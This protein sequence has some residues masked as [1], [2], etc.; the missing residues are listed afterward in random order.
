MLPFPLL[1]V[2]AV[3]ADLSKT[4]GSTILS[5]R[6]ALSS[7]EFFFHFA[8][9]SSYFL[10]PFSSPP[11]PPNPP[12]TTTAAT[13][14]IRTRTRT[15]TETQLESWIQKLK[16]RFTPMD[17][18]DALQAQ[19]DADLAFDIFRWTSLQRHYKHTDSTYLT[20]I[21]ILIYGKRFRHAETLAE[22]VIAGACQPSVPLYNAVI[23]FC[24]ARKFL[25]NH[26]FDVYKKMLKSDDCKP[27]LET[28]TLLLNLLLKKFNRM[29]VCYMYLHSVRSMTKQMKSLGV[30]PD[31]F[32]L[33]MIIKAY[34]KCLD[35][36]EAIR[37]FREMGL[38]GCVPNAY[39]YSYIIKG[40]CEKGRVGQGFGFYK[41]MR[42]NSLVPRASAYM[43]LICSLAIERRV[44]DALD[45]V[46]DMFGNYM[47]P[48]VLTY[49]TV[50]E[51]LC[52]E[53]RSNDAFEL[54]EK[55]RKKD[56]SMGERNYRTL[57][58]KLHFI[59]RE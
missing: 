32:V 58:E 20:M 12:P 8:N 9:P 4:P 10:R 17:V 14:L 52:R 29:N 57:L 40:S 51:E 33:N 7:S 28:Y 38:Y 15:P 30:I 56:Q 2:L 46:S 54:L 22:E 25:F 18:E 42:E 13:S 37:V 49:K 21:K 23:R 1:R 48:D 27:T 6:S 19:S 31:T 24:C 11:E 34:A 5:I 16:P 45:I 53:G 59:G 55:W 41:E 44:G 26:A 39:T 47:A 36:D 43:V 3:A 50:L 35:V